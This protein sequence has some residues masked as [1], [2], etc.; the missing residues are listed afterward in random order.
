M[1]AASLVRV[2]LVAVA[3]AV[4]AGVGET[5]GL[6]AAWA[7]VVGVAIS[8]SG[9]G[10]VAPRGLTSVVGAAVAMALLGLL[11]PGIGEAG[12]AGVVVALV[13][14]ATGMLR[15]VDDPRMP[16]VALLLGGGTALAQAQVAGDTG[17]H[18]T[19]PALAGLVAGLVPMQ[20]AE[21]LG[22]AR[23]ATDRDRRPDPE[24]QT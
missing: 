13:V 20:L 9:R 2:G 23:A 16:A 5:T 18:A 8:L 21:I 17:L 14:A 1:N 19:A 10:P 4:I 24:E 7:V 22:R 3:V 15:V 12:A 11:T 6:A